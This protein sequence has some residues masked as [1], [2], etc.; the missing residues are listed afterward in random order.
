MSGHFVV[1]FLNRDVE[2]E[3]QNLM[4]LSEDSSVLQSRN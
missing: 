2:K 1:G 3:Y 4:D